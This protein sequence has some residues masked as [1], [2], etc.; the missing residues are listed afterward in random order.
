MKLGV[1]K[2]ALAGSLADADQVFCYG[3]GLGWDPAEAL[4][5]LGARATTEHELPALVEAIA[6]A[7]RPGDH[8]LVM[9]NGGFG[10]VHEK[11]LARLRQRHGG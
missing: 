6:Q 5:P 10:G 9:S 3:G 11:L 4:A 2:D 1:M 8:V 7:A